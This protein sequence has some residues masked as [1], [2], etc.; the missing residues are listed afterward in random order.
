MVIREEGDTTN[1]PAVVGRKNIPPTTIRG[2]VTRRPFYPFGIGEQAMALV[3]GETPIHLAQKLRSQL[4]LPPRGTGLITGTARTGLARG[5]GK[6]LTEIQRRIRHGALAG[7]IKPV[8]TR[9]APLL[10]LLKITFPLLGQTIKN[11]PSA[12]ERPGTWGVTRRIA[13]LPSVSGILD[14]PERTVHPSAH[15]SVAPFS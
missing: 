9:P 6:P 7:Q 15:L 10:S 1:Y 8:L 3:R 12:Y 2:Q 5:M 13:E 14:G 4:K 11:I